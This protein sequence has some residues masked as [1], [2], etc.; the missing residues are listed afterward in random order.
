MSKFK[1][2]EFV[3]G[4]A[5][6]TIAKHG[7]GFSKKAIAE[8]GNPDYVR[9]LI[10]ADDK[11]LALVVAN[12]GE[13]GAIKCMA[14]KNPDDNRN[15]R[16]VSKDLLH[17]IAHM[18]KCPFDEMNFKIVG[19]YFDDNKVMLIDLQRARKVD[20]GDESDESL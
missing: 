19:E 18:M 11:Q 9:F 15:F 6:A 16:I 4:I 20:K 14:G 12:E 7:I 3:P 5:S 1:G 10:N 13:I 2:Y 17:K 8:L